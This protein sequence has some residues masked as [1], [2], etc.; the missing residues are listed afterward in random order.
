MSM[1][2]EI[3]VEGKLSIGTI[4]P[5]ELLDYCL[6]NG[7]KRINSLKPLWFSTK[8]GKTQMVDI[9]TANEMNEQ[10][11]ADISPANVWEIDYN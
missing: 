3:K 8:D 4:T 1:V 10:T 9:E 5:Q 7:V 2:D 6:K 11:G